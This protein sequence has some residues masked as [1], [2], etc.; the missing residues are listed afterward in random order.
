DRGVSNHRIASVTNPEKAVFI[1][2]EGDD[3]VAFEMAGKGGIG[4]RPA[5]RTDPKKPAGL[6]SNPQGAIPGADY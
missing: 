2:G 1:E 4:E 5:G 6:R 3:L